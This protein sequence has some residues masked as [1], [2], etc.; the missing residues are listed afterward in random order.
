MMPVLNW[1]QYNIFML[2]Q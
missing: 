1:W 2:S